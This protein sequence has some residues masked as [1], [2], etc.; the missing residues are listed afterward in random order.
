M[1]KMI[2]FRVTR[3]FRHRYQNNSDS[4]AVAKSPKSPRIPV[5]IWLLRLRR[6]LRHWYRNWIAWVMHVTTHTVFKE[7]E[8]NG[9][10]NFSYQPSTVI[11]C[12][13]K[14][15]LDIP[16]VVPSLYYHQRPGHL[17]DLKN[18]Y[19]PAR[20]D[21]YERGFLTVYFPWL[22][23]LRFLIKRISVAGNFRAVQACPVKLPDEQ[24]VNQLLNETLRLEGNLRLQEALTPEW[25]DRLMGELPSNSPLC[26]TDA[27]QLAPLTALA[28][29]ATP[30]MF[31]EPLASKIR[32]RHHC[33][34]MTQLRHLTRILDKGGS[35]FIAPE[36]RVTPDGRFGKMRAA[37]TRIVQQAYVDVRM[38][39]INLTYDFMDTERAKVIVNIGPEVPSLKKFSKVELG[40][41]V[42]QEIGKLGTVTMSGLASKRLIEA[43]E[44]GSE[45][46]RYCQLRDDVWQELEQLREAGLFYDRRLEN[47]QSFEE[48]LLRFVD[49]GFGKGQLFL[50]NVAQPNP[51]AAAD[52]ASD[53]NPAYDRWLHLNRE[54]MLRLECHKP[55]DNPA[56]YSYNELLSL[57][58]AWNLLEPKQEPAQLVFKLGVE[59]ERLTA[60]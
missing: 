24:T 7:V 50:D 40:Q 12:A 23:A 5:F 8:V 41:L 47:R 25:S 2:K 51:T 10:E 49:Y 9:K 48:R 43:C 3:Q 30:R 45:R 21:L 6:D 57:L 22:N 29:Y 33:T 56:R 15:D 46:I 44:A 58:E 11:V 16:V 53:F 52:S 32:E 28:Q 13:H 18:L 59:Q 42:K 26:L 35:L 14:R 39:P 54:A 38:L 55:E 19:F 17:K 37:F 36:G 4:P 27:I 1:G 60:G 34:I 20:D 31:A